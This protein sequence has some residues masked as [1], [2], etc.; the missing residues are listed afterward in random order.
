MYLITSKWA[1]ESRVNASQTSMKMRITPYKGN[2]PASFPLRVVFEKI[3]ASERFT[4]I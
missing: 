3:R 2:Y 1:S 4:M